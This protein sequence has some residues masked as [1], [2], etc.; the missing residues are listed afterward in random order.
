MTNKH[1]ST[2]NIITV[3][4]S[5]NTAIASSVEDTASE[6]KTKT[7]HSSAKQLLTLAKSFAIDGSLLPPEKQMPLQ[8]RVAKRALTSAQRQQ[9]NLEGIIVKAVNYCSTSKIVEQVDADW[10]AQFMELAQGVS[11]KTMQD[12][13]AKILAKEISYPGAFAIKTLKVFKDLSIHDAKL[14]AKATAIALR[15]NA[16]RHYRILSG[17][18]QVPSLWNSF[19]KSRT[20]TID[21]AKFGLSYSDLLALAN[22]GLLFAQE[23]E[24]TTFDKHQE[25][26]L[27]F[28]GQPLILQSVKKQTVLKYYKYSEVGCELARLITD[29]PDESI[30]QSLTHYIG[31]HFTCK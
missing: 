22:N 31:H 14:F 16:G 27:I 8:D 13:W 5:A 4:E 12:L 19:D 15:D 26:A 25:L 28:Q 20:A 9:L 3:N 11:N 17:S 6:R 29:K 7:G 10:F 24:T 23:T 1:A 2:D 30:K 21:L 18:Y